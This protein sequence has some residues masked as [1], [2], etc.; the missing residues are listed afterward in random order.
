MGS[1][2]YFSRI[3]YPLIYY[4]RPWNVLSI[5]IF[6]P[7][8]LV[9]ADGALWWRLRV[10][11][12]IFS[13]IALPIIIGLARVYSF[14]TPRPKHV[15]AALTSSLTFLCVLILSTDT[16]HQYVEILV[17]IV[18]HFYSW[19]NYIFI[20]WPCTCIPW[21]IVPHVDIPN[22]WYIV[23]GTWYLNSSPPILFS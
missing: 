13:V 20:Y 16:I 21:G 22:I 2:F 23:N 15:G 1:V 9:I 7:S 18:E 3:F 11:I 8:I 10:N 19:Y 5:L 12:C 6:T 17:F 4:Y 14:A